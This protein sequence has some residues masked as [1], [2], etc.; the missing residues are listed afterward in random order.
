MST[1][2]QVISVYAGLNGFIDNLELPFVKSYEYLLFNK[3]FTV[4][5]FDKLIFSSRDK[6]GIGKLFMLHKEHEFSFYTQVFGIQSYVPYLKRWLQYTN[7][8]F[9]KYIQDGFKFMSTLRREKILL[10]FYY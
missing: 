10:K 7:T 3:K 8:Y 9:S 1:Y 2:Q 6:L 5:L 4:L